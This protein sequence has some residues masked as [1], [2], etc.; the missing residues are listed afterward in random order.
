[1]THFEVAAGDVVAVGDG[2]AII[3]PVAGFQP[4]PAGAAGAVVVVADGSD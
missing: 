4:N 1:V 3:D 2:D